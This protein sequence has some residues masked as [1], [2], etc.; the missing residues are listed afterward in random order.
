[1]LLRLA[2][3]CCSCGL[4]GSAEAVESDGVLEALAPGSATVVRSGRCA[5]LGAARHWEGLRARL[6]AGEPVNILAIGSSIVG[7]HGGCTAPAPVLAQSGC[8][9]QCPKCC[10]SK[11]GQWGDGGW[12]R[13]VFSWINATYPV[14]SAASPTPGGR[15]G[16]KI[17]VPAAAR[18]HE[19]YNLG[20]P[21]WF[22]PVPDPPL[23]SVTPV[24]LQWYNT[25]ISVG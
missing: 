20:E 13:H 24:A 19:L 16:T 18:Q 6:H 10:G 21:V 17:G 15:G 5:D 4:A 2:C 25:Q 12:A 14:R 7:V 9:A 1:M 3:L 23:P 22:C 8:L 11:C